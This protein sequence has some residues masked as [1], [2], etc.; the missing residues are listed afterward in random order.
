MVKKKIK[1]KIQIKRK[2]TVSKSF[3]GQK[4]GTPNWKFYAIVSTPRAAP[5]FSVTPYS[6]FLFQD[7]FLFVASH[8][9]G[10]VM[11][12]VRVFHLMGVSA[13]WIGDSVAFGV[14]VAWALST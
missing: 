14:L 2:A 4:V 1:K 8:K 7:I 12:Q 6:L 10:Y 11:G 13:G 5:P 3:L 9:T